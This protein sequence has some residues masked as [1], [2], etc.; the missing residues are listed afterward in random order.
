MAQ[1]RMQAGEAQ[2]LLPTNLKVGNQIESL[3]LFKSAQ[4]EVIRIALPAGKTLPEHAVPGEI[5]L[6]CLA[7]AIDLVHAPEE[8]VRLQAGELIYLKGGV[9]HAL[10]GIRDSWLLLTICLLPG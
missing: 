10:T 1:E 9:P 6:Q 5:T 3:A 2:G 8:T 4:L 7:G